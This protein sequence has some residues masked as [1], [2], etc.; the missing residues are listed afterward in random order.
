[1]N[2][3]KLLLLTLSMISLCL[4]ALSFS[5]ATNTG[6]QFFIS[7]NFLPY[8]IKSRTAQSRAD[9]QQVLEPLSFMVWPKQRSV[10]LLEAE[11]LIQSEI[12]LRP[13]D[14]ELWRA[15]AFLQQD[16]PVSV[17][18]KY[19]V[20]KNAFLVAA[21]NPK[22]IPWLAK[23]C[24]IHYAEIVLIDPVLC[25]AIFDRFPEHLST[26]RIAHDMSLQQFELEAFLERHRLLNR[27][28]TD[29]DV[30]GDAK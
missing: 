30:N 18:Q 14:P 13:Y 27:R 21:W 2:L 11:R 10:L 3:V 7:Q 12:N 19:W 26:R 25:K 4:C 22:A 23:S 29:S 9:V 8:P 5:Q 16:K 24:F 28:G 15:L 6:S 1:M 17:E 20:L